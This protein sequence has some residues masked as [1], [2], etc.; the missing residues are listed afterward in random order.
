MSRVKALNR[1][2][3][4]TWC[5]ARTPGQR[6]C[7]HVLHQGTRM[8]DG[9]FQECVDEYNERM[10]AKLNSKNEQ[11]RIECAERGY[12]LEVLKNDISKKVRNIAKQKLSEAQTQNNN[13]ENS[14]DTHTHNIST[15]RL[16]NSID[17]EEIRRHV[18]EEAK[19]FDKELARL[20]KEIDNED[21]PKPVID[22]YDI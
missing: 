15:V 2:G 5:T 14:T 18:D 3:K 13:T 12:G 9:E 11:D 7:N 20:E 10:M 16:V 8:T 22:E 6:N 4:I 17:G 19:K 21:K 1:D